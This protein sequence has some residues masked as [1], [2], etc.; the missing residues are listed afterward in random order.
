MAKSNLPSHVPKPVYPG[1]VAAMK[2]FVGANLKYP[3]KA[4][5]A[6]VE[7]TVTLRYGLDYRGVVTDVKVKKSL[8]HGCDKEAIRVVKLMRFNVPQDRKKKV[9]IHQDINIHF[10]LPKAK[11]MAPQPQQFTVNYVS[12]GTVKGKVVKGKV[13]KKKDAGNSY[14]YTINW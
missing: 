1:G 6:K 4:L 5:E 14:S 10:K 12:S 2:K 7:G 11:P 13:V 3:P 8:G 9:R